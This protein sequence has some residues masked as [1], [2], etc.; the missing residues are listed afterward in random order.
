MRNKTRL[1]EMEPDCFNWASQFVNK[2]KSQA[3]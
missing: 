2:M 1:K 3:K